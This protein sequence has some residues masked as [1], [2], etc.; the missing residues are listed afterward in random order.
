MREVGNLVS[1]KRADCGGGRGNTDENIKYKINIKYFLLLSSN[2]YSLKI[3]QLDHLQK[4]RGL[5]KWIN[6]RMKYCSKWNLRHN[7]NRTQFMVFQK[8]KN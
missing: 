4:K 3:S 5:Q 2:Y 6:Q 1:L 7:F 8:Q